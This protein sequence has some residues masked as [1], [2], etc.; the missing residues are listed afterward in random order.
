VDAGGREQILRSALRLFAE[1]GID[2]VSMRAI[3]AAAGVSLGLIWKYY[4]PKEALRAAVDEHVLE[5]LERE[6]QRL[7]EREDAAFL[8]GLG[9]E[10][11][12]P[13]EEAAWELRYLRRALLDCSPASMRMFSRYF[14]VERA[15]FARLVDE[16]ALRS[17]LDMKLLT[18][19]SIFI[20]LGPLLLEP[21]F[22]AVF[23]ED[24]F[25]PKS[26]G[27]RTAF[28]SELMARGAGS[29]A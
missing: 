17:D 28:F 3:A 25:D 8:G 15:Y 7:L 23:E 14:E 26:I 22:N 21:Y 6:N 20:G 4:G 9:G 18:M 1:K 10:G 19:T 13:S 16:G 11:A 29:A 27:R 5:A 24:I 12:R 2:G